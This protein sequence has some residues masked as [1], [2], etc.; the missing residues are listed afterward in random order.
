MGRSA[1]IVVMLALGAVLS[2][3]TAPR[4]TVHSGDANSVEVSYAG[5]VAG[6]L[7]VARGHCAQFER[8]PRLVD[9]GTDIAIYDCVRR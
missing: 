7:P 2:G 3:C 8:V 6:T 5:A 4:P 9:A 1:V